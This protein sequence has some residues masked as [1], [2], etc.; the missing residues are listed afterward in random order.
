PRKASWTWPSTRRWSH[1]AKPEGKLPAA[2]Y[3]RA[4]GEL[5][6]LFVF[7]KTAS[8]LANV[9]SINRNQVASYI[10]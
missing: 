8:K 9:Y 10:A 6:F 2:G 3:H 7:E 4:A 1:A 5:A